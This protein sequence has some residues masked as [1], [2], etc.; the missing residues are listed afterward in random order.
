MGQSENGHCLSPNGVVLK[1][2][3]SSSSLNQRPFSIVK[4]ERRCSSKSSV[5]FSYGRLNGGRPSAYR[6]LPPAEL[7]INGGAPKKQRLVG[8]RRKKPKR[9]ETQAKHTIFRF[10]SRT[11]IPEI[12]FPHQFWLKK[13]ERENR[14]R[15]RE[16][17]LWK[18]S[19]KTKKNK[20]K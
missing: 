20:L 6:P 3:C 17:V 1:G 4:A 13:N 18:Q 16:T 7:Y 2:R 9:R 15:E 12:G 19:I 10:I 8:E 14:P 11:P 5:G